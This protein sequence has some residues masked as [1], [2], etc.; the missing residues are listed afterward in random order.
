[1]S[2]EEGEPEIEAVEPR[3]GKADQRL[4]SAGEPAWEPPEQD[5]YRRRPS[6]GTSA[7][8]LEGDVLLTPGTS[9]I[10]ACRL[11]YD[12]ERDRAIILTRLFVPSCPTATSRYTC[13]RTRFG[14]ARQFAATNAKVTTSEFH[15]PH[16]HVAPSDRVTDTTTVT[17]DARSETPRATT[18]ATPRST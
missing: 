6:G 9:F 8:Y 7:V 4:R 1:M 2:G 16:Y 11:Y 17:E 13:G 15:T 5:R 12:F 14:A 18:F 3:P 10:R